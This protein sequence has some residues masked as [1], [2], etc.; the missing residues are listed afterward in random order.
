MRTPDCDQL[1]EL[2]FSPLVLAALLRDTLPEVGIS[3]LTPTSGGLDL[4]L[5]LASTII[6]DILAYVSSTR[7]SRGVSHSSTVQAGCC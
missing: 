1:R 3:T 4:T 6:I 2:L 5:P 7:N